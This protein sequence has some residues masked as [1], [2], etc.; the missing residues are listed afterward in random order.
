MLFWPL[1]KAVCLLTLLRGG[2]I[3]IMFKSTGT[4]LYNL[5]SGATTAFTA[6]EYIYIHI[7]IHADVTFSGDGLLCILG[8]WGTGQEHENTVDSL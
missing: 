7:K 1:M 6:V 2:V 3:D 5:P 4:H 8:Q